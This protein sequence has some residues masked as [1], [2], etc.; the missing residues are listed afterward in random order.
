M[1]GY[2]WGKFQGW[3]T[4]AIGLLTWAPAIWSFPGWDKWIGEIAVGV[5]LMPLGLGL[6]HKQRFALVLLYAMLPIFILAFI[7]LKLPPFE[8]A[9][10]VCWY[11]IPAIF[12]YPK[13][14]KEFSHGSG[15]KREKS[16]SIN[17]TPELPA[18]TKYLPDLGKYLASKGAQQNTAFVYNSWD[19]DEL[20][21]RGR[22]HY[23]T[24]SVQPLDGSLYC[25][26]F[27]FGDDILKEILARAT[28]ETE[29]AVLGNISNDPESIRHI[30]ISIP[31]NTGV[32]AVLG[33]IE[34]GLDETFIPLQI[35]E[36]FGLRRISSYVADG[37]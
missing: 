17:A 13:R 29:A 30:P 6:V 24:T 3:A 4:F 5:T 25:A 9:F 14:W 36:V 23:C 10:A 26:T 18:Q 27:D 7:F 1:R 32:V 8:V 35:T 19:M 34:Q 21:V 11:F 16:T 28:L 33:H 12:Y 15:E 37:G 31:I 2:R 20:A 22:G